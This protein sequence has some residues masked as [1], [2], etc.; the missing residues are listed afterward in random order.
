[1]RLLAAVKCSERIMSTVEVNGASIAAVILREADVD[2]ESDDP[3]ER[4]LVG[5]EN[6][7]GVGPQ[8]ADHGVLTPGTGMLLDG[9]GE[10]K[11]SLAALSKRLVVPKAFV[12]P[13]RAEQTIATL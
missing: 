5:G 4:G 6:D 9:E 8:G 10:F 12:E 3:C 13:D 11:A 1:M 2:L 7:G